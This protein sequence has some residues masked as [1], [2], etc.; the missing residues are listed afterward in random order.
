MKPRTAGVLG[1]VVALIVTMFSG[2]LLAAPPFSILGAL[3]LAGGT[4]LLV[5]AASWTVRTSWNASGWPIYVEPSVT[6]SRR[7]LWGL[8]VAQTIFVALAVGAGTSKLIVGDG[9]GWAT[10]GYSG[11]FIMQVVVILFVLLKKPPP[12]DKSVQP[13]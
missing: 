6:K 10:I 13:R 1:I 5:A 4:I 9:N 11:L 7:F 12:Q 3:G 2:A 8:V